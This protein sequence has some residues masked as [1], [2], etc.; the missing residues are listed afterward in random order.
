MNELP[1]GRG[2]LS[3]LLRNFDSQIRRLE[4]RRTPGMLTE[5]RPD[6][7]LQRPASAIFGKG[8]G[9]KNSIPRYG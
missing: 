6:G 1:Q 9:G 8:G 3:K 7:V 4:P 2:K 5:V